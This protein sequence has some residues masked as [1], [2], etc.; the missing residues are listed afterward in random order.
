MASDTADGSDPSPL[1]PPAAFRHLVALA[2]RWNIGDDGYRW[3]AVK[4]AS[5]EERSELVAGVVAVEDELLAWL[6]GPEADRRPFT[7]TYLAFS[8]LL[9]ASMEAR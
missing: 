4:Q 8:N 7:A 6:T 5:A 9:M 2:R 3:A 1:D